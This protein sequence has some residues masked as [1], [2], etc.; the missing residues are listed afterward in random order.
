MLAEKKVSKNLEIFLADP[1]ILYKG[2]ETGSTYLTMPDGTKIAVDILLPKGLPPTKRVPVVLT[3]GRYWRSFE[4]RIP[5]QPG[6]APIAPRAMF[7]DYLIPRGYAMVVVD[8]RGSGASTGSSPYPW[9]PAEIADYAEVVRWVV[10]QPWCNGAVGA[11]GLS[12]E[13]TTAQLVAATGCPEV[14]AVVPQAVEFDVYSDVALPGGIFNEAFIKAWS[15]SNN[16]LDRNKMS[17]LFPFQAKLFCKGVRPVDSDKKERAILKKA[18]QD[19]RQNSDVYQ[20]IQKIT[21][22]DDKYGNENITLDD[23]SI[24]K[25]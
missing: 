21:Y 2:V 3:L 23:F 24:F 1:P 18:L 5:P 8:V 19:H 22:R 12:Y 9:S 16:L 17:D 14:K 20:A 15:D 13:G 10:Q 6:K 4:L 7:A 11:V 25:Y